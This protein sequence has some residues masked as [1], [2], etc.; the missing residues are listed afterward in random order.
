[1]KSRYTVQHEI[2]WG[3]IAVIMFKR[4][5][6]ADD[7]REVRLNT[8]VSLPRK[9]RINDRVLKRNSWIEH[10]GTDTGNGHY[11]AFR[12]VRSKVIR[13]DDEIITDVPASENINSDC[14]TMVTYL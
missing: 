10:L 2:E 3:K 4:G 6:R 12:K 8:K 13:I 7:N 9:I 5:A 1:M 11:V 14:V